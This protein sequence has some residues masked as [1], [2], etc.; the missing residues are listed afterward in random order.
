MSRTPIHS[1]LRRAF[2]QAHH[3][4]LGG[5]SA[6][7][8]AVSASSAGR[9]KRRRFLKLSALAG[10]AA[11]ATQLPHLDEVWGNTP[12]KIAIIGGGLAGLT[13]A[14]WL[15]QA[16][17]MATVYEARNRLGG[18]VHSVINQV[19]T[20]QVDELG[21][22]FINTDHTDL[23][24]LVEALGLDLF[25]REIYAETV[26]APATVYFIDG[27]RISEVEVAENL[28]PLAAQV[29]ADLALL[30]E[31][32]DRYAPVLDALSVQDYL[33]RH[34]DK[35]PAP[36]IRTLIE[37][38]VRTEYGVEAEQS[39]VIQ[40]LYS[41]PAVEGDEADLLS[42]SDEAFLIR[43]G[44][45]QLIDRLANTLPNQI[46]TRM[47]LTQLVGDDRGFQLRFAN[48]TAVE[49]DYVILAIPF[50]ALRFVDLQVRL[51][52]TLQRFIQE[53]E[54]GLNEKIFVGFRERFWESPQGFSGVA[55]TD[56]G[57]A[58]VWDSTQQQATEYSEGVLT[59]YHGGHEVTLMQLRSPY[60]QNRQLLDQAELLLPGAKAAATGRFLHSHWHSNP[61]SRGAYSTFKPGQYTEFGAFFYI[62]G[63][64]DADR[65]E[66]AV[67]NLIF[68][69][70]HLSDAF[71]GYMNGAVETGRMAASVILRQIQQETQQEAIA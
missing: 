36:F 34:A 56:L 9:W 8:M 22:S 63:E 12:P 27:R 25:S 11:I 48:D 57:F 53:S 40:L 29:A 42:S 58:E 5:S 4:N 16:G 33:D 37:L 14:Y 1:L 64:T 44:N 30:E 50:T 45:Q 54:L 6:P 18:R 32:F 67:G 20:G 26:N 62:D 10:G 3:S 51:P 19:S 47:V 41:L 49:V 55:W 71:Y 43:G 15:K 65:Q 69:G 39:S 52:E 24:A 68:A 38:T 23:L 7:S 17:V 61:Y 13:A 70:E 28:R 2:R 21:G 66:V 35:I 60:Q 59:F 46:Q 31:D